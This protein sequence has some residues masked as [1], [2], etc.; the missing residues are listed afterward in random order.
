MIK[1]H[2]LLI[3]FLFL[4]TIDSFDL[5]KIDLHV[6]KNHLLKYSKPKVN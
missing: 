6:N 2:K 4:N 1:L 3:N 5:I